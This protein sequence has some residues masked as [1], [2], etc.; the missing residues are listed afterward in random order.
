MNSK[1]ACGALARGFERP[2]ATSSV[3][4]ATVE[5]HLRS[6]FSKLEVTSRHELA[7]SPRRKD[8]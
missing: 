6:I 7:C 3:S 5:L 2:G 8:H 1:T 4:R